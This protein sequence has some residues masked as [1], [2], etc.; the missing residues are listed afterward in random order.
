MEPTRTRPATGAQR[1]Y[2]ADLLK[3]FTERELPAEE[4]PDPWSAALSAQDAS[5]ALDKLIRLKRCTTTDERGI[6]L[7]AQ[8]CELH[9]EPAG[10]LPLEN[11]TVVFSGFRDP[12]LA[13]QIANCGG[14]VEDR[15]TKS[16][17]TRLLTWQAP[18]VAPSRK[19]LAAR[20]YGIPVE[21]RGEFTTRFYK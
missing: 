6:V 18:D 19:T 9:G 13:A 8:R 7:V 1:R 20:R 3:G 5:G 10:T 11:E 17:T 4:R 12:T 16:R 2:L 15:L 14:T 21:H